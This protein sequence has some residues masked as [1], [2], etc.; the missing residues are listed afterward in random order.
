MARFPTRWL[1]STMPGA[2]TLN[3]AAGSLIAVLNAALTTGFGSKTLDSLT[4]DPAS[5]LC[6][7]TISAGHGFLKYQ[8]ILVA[9]ANQA[10][11]NGEQRVSWV[12]GTQFRYVPASPPAVTTATGTL[13]VKTAPLPSWEQAFSGA[14]KAM[15]RSTHI[16]SNGGLLLVDDTNTYGGWNSGY[17]A[18]T[19]TW[20]VETATDINTYTAQYGG[21]WVKKTED[22]T[23]SAARQWVLVGDDVLF[24]L[25]T[26]PNSGGSPYRQG[27]SVL[28]YGQFLSYRAG[29]G[30]G[31]LLVNGT[32]YVGV[33]SWCP[34]W[35]GDLNATSQKTLARA[36]TQAAG[37][38]TAFSCRGSGVSGYLGYNTGTGSANPIDNGVYIHDQVLILE[39]NYFRGEL[40]GLKQPIVTAP[41]T[42]GVIL[43]TLPGRIGQLYLPL[44]LGNTWNNGALAQGL[45]SLEAWR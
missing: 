42:H 1:M 10:E 36:Y 17:A 31:S 25:V 43:D 32:N 35:F 15:Y 34:T 24:Y 41:F 23:A 37:T 39:G 3:N 21:G 18:Y 7:G 5:G 9:G 12:S 8:V 19:V 45:W 13:T 20:G 38:P 6:T 33:A 26:Y 40:P 14:N 28:A 30:Y 22:Y 27:A 11:F 29:E 16:Q 2:P 44:S 4:Y